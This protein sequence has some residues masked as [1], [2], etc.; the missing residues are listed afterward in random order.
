MRIA[1]ALTRGGTG[2]MELIIQRKQRRPQSGR[3][4]ISMGSTPCYTVSAGPGYFSIGNGPG[5]YAD[6]TGAVFFDGMD[7]FYVQTIKIIVGKCGSGLTAWYNHRAG[8][9]SYNFTFSGM[10]I[11]VSA[12]A[13]KINGDCFREHTGGNGYTGYRKAGCNGISTRLPPGCGS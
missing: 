9:Y 3:L 2:N 6:A 13:A 8:T 12:A 4:S 10:A 1:V 11:N 5:K 7:T